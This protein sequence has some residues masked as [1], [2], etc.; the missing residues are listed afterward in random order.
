M[1]S[2]PRA[3]AMV[4]SGLWDSGTHDAWHTSLLVVS[5]ADLIEVA[6]TISSV[7]RAAMSS[8]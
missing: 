1:S 2:P 8:Y 6:S 4:L 5:L 7:T 3:P